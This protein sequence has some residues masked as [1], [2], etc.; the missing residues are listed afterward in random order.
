MG[1]SS[2]KVTTTTPP[3]DYYKLSISTD[4]SHHLLNVGQ[5]GTSIVR[6]FRKF[7]Y[8]ICLILFLIYPLAVFGAPSDPVSIPDPT[9]RARIEFL[10]NK[11]PGDTITEQE[12]S[13][14]TRL[15]LDQNVDLIALTGL[16]YAT[17][18]TYL[19]LFR[20]QTARDSTRSSLDLSPLTGLTKL[21]FLSLQGYR[22]TNISPLSTLTELIYLSLNRTHD[23]TDLSPLSTLTKL[24]SLTLTDNDITNLT[25]IQ[26]L[27]E[28]RQLVLSSN[29]KISDIS[30]L[31]K[32][33]NLANLALTGT[34]ITDESF[35]ALLPSFVN[36]DSP[37]QVLDAIIPAGKLIISNTD[38]T[39]LSVLGRFPENVFLSSL[40]LRFMGRNRENL[41][42]NLKDLTPLVDLMNAGRL[43]NSSSE[44]VLL[45]NYG[46]D[47]ESHY[48][49]IPALLGRARYLP[50]QQGST[51]TLEREFPT[52]ESWR[53][54]PKISYTFAVRAV[55]THDP[56]PR[57]FPWT[58]RTPGGIPNNRKFSEVPVT[59]IVTAPDGTSETRG[60]V[61]TGDDGLAR[62]PVTLG[63]DGETHTVEAVVPANAPTP[64]EIEHAEL[65]VT[66][67][68]TADITVPPPVPSG[69]G[70]GGG[71]TLSRLSFP[72]QISFSELMFAPGGG[73][74]RFPQW[75]E[76]YNAS[77]TATVNLYGWHFEIERQDDTGA[78]QYTDL[79]LKDLVIPPQ[80]VGLIVTSEGP[81]SVNLPQE[82]ICVLST[83]HPRLFKDT[84]DPN[85]FLGQTAFCLQLSDPSGQVSDTFGNLDGNKK[86]EDAPAFALLDGSTAY[87]AR[88]SLLRRY[89]PKEDTPL[90]G[91][92]LENCYRAADVR[93]EFITY[94]GYETDIG[95]PGHKDQG[96]PFPPLHRVHFSELML[97]SRGGL[98]S[99][100]QW[101]ELYNISETESVDLNGWRLKIESLDANDDRRHAFIRL[102][103]LI[104]PPKESALLVTWNAPHSRDIPMGRVYNLYLHHGNSFDQHNH[105]HRNKVFGQ[106]GFF[107]KLYDA[108]GRVQDI[109]GNLDG[110]AETRDTPAWVLPPGKTADGER[111]SLQRRY[112]RVMRIPLDGKTSAS[113]GSTSE[114]PLPVQT[115]WGRSADIGTPGLTNED[116]LSP[117]PSV[118]FSE[119]LFAARG[120]LHSLPQ[121]IELRNASQTEPVNL[122]GW[123]L[124]IEAQ[125]ETGAHRHI[126]LQL[127][128]LRIPPN[129]VALLVTQHGLA[130]RSMPKARLYNLLM[131]HGATFRDGTH[132]NRVIGLKGFS[133][134]L[135][136][137][138]GRVSDTM[139]NLDGDK[140][141]RDTPRWELGAGKTA[142]GVRTSLLR[143]YDK[144][145]QAFDG[146]ASASWVPASE[147]PLRVRT[148]YGQETDIG[149]PGYVNEALRLRGD[150]VSFSELMFPSKVGRR[151]VRSVPQW[152]ELYNAADTEIVN[153]KGWSLEIEALTGNGEH[154]HT[155]ITLNDLILRPNETA[156][157][158]TAA[159]PHSQSM[160]TASIYNLLRQHQ[161]VFQ[162]NRG[163]N[164]VLGEQGFFLRLRDP[165]GSRSD[166]IG[167]LDGD[168]QT[169]DAPMWELPVVETAEG[170]R[171]SLLRR[172]YHVTGIPL[173]GKVASN[174][175]SAVNL[176]LDVMW[177]YGQ[178][179]DIGNP[180]HRG[181]G[182]LPV[183]L[184]SFRAE[185]VDTGVVIKWTTASEKDN[186]GFN[187]LRSQI[188]QGPFVKI[189]PKRI[190][191]HG[192]T[193]ERHTYT[194]TDTTAKPNVVY[195]YRLEEVSFSGAHRQLATVRLRGHVSARGKLTTTWSDLK[196]QP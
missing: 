35:S 163:S 113:W 50:Y 2:V 77:E 128:D 6:P 156:L 123:H 41:Y 170:A 72:G 180:G 28:L 164:T 1:I 119:F 126:R 150:Q 174:W 158:V 10:L 90:D 62:V 57:G 13:G 157:L 133:L 14:L 33:I 129:Q 39:D 43:I 130:S 149:N 144:L 91:T 107:L 148:Y 4:S 24:R 67:T 184:S 116:L 12:M 32:L 36:F 194:W 177:Y 69:G 155:V 11:N 168:P 132:R 135:L 22:I 18:L 154:W 82:S 142:D 17:E 136:T 51:P 134:K 98:H 171:A 5:N 58:P 19:L 121:W 16:E 160:P 145:G 66:F 102:R 75:I 25:P 186:A 89:D 162:R 88:T 105:Q 55:N 44:I 80:Q 193:S 61:L 83:H 143:Q 8:C 140:R 189:T 190:A 95:N 175:V 127:K 172:Y 101:I 79:T 26:S 191:G 60:P 104:I 131:H 182:P 120:G 146:T 151:A 15:T 23:I 9:L 3:P 92:L 100:P 49:D 74:D 71:G 195:Y 106:H 161:N 76:L 139:G 53:G 21:E 94:Y 47:Y 173:D 97:T 196:Q 108:D 111:V 178:E 122:R 56:L 141:T 181:G 45:Y 124:E 167:N 73:R 85:N 20:R 81:T 185:H 64:G 46:L 115:Y 93:L 159:G 192:T 54:H 63:E 138:D 179:T 87:G 31:S 109:A 165:A 99:L 96:G 7:F 110:A 176:P 48:A 114:I 187:I 112:E 118:S 37:I 27:T 84:E 152:I 59:F 30:P 103:R 38:I 40:D 86:T 78:Y 188:R 169:R 147:K 125:D 29:S 42:F 68:A 153:L 70:G 117:Y 52:E 65:R 183:V 137:P 34:P 166:V